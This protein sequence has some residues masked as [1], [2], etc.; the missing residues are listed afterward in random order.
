M[1]ARSEKRK[2]VVE[3]LLSELILLAIEELVEILSDP[4][5]DPTEKRTARR[6]ARQLARQGRKDRTECDNRKTKNV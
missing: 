2:R 5:A 3:A 6:L 1:S 4:Q